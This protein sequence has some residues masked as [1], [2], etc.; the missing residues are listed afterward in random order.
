MAY[1]M[2]L[3]MNP[4]DSNKAAA[5]DFGPTF[6]K[7]MLS[8]IRDAEKRLT[9]L[10]DQPTATPEQIMGAVLA[11]RSG[12]PGIRDTEHQLIGSAVLGGAAVTTTAA[13]LV[14]RPQTLAAWLA[15]T[16]AAVRGQELYFD[17]ASSEWK[18]R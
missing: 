16:V 10:A 2:N 15:K 6:A 13:K 3:K 14:V 18:T 8:Q 9:E 17:P 7:L 12:Q 11:W 5:A 1:E 4:T